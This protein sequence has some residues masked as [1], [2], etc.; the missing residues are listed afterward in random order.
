MCLSIVGVVYFS[1]VANQFVQNQP[2]TKCEE[3]SRKA[4]NEGKK[5]YLEIKHNPVL[6]DNGGFGV[7]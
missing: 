3:F 4:S 7:L 1:V 6:T 2:E 5:C